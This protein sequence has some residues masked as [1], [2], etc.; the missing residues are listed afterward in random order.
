MFWPPEP[1]KEQNELIQQAV[2]I[3]MMYWAHK[4]GDMTYKKWNRGNDL[5][6]R[7][8]IWTEEPIISPVTYNP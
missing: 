7:R 5:I 2:R 1:P 4:H 6:H 8:Q 3:R